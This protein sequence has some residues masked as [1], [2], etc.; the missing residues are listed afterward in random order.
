[1]SHGG[2]VNRIGE[3][4]SKFP[5]ENSRFGLK[6]G[7]RCFFRLF[8]RKRRGKA[9]PL[10]R[11]MAKKEEVQSYDRRQENRGLNLIV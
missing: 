7:R 5:I 11:L 6:I 2:I 3:G 8:M 10:H 1:M 4:L 9:V